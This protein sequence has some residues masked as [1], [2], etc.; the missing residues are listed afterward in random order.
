M[1]DA[2]DS[3]SLPRAFSSTTPYR[4]VVVVF[5]CFFFVVGGATEAMVGSQHHEVSFR[6]LDGNRLV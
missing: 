2:D 5:F 4:F 1:C 6:V 3:S